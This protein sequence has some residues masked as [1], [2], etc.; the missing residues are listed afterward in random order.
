MVKKAEIKFKICDI[1]DK[2]NEYHMWVIS[3]AT[4]LQDLT[5]ITRTIFKKCDRNT[6]ESLYYFKIAMGHIRESFYLIDRGLNSSVKDII[7]KNKN[8]EK[9]YEDI[10]ILCDGTSE[11]SF[12]HK[13]LKGTRHQIF[14]Y[15]KSNKEFIH[16]KRILE[17][18]EKNNFSSS[19]ILNNSEKLNNNYAFAE[20]IQL[21]CIVKYGEDYNLSYEELFEKITILMAKIMNI[22]EIIVADFIKNINHNI[23]YKILTR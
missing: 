5:I 2:N 20:E 14:H 15:N 19:V 1:I 23:C 7:L 8:I 17:E 6:P 11:D 16:V 22:L 18:L 9:L 10:K 4:A 3:F 13:V 21:N 12:V